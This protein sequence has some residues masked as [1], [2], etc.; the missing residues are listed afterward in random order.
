MKNPK[1]IIFSYININSIRNKFDNLCDLI[2]KNIDI[3][4]VTETKLDPYFSNSQFLIPGFHEPM[5]L[6]V[7]SKRGGMLVYIKSSLPS[8]IMSNFKLPK[9]IQVIPFEL[10]L[11]KEKWFFVSIFKPPLQ[12]NNYFLDTLNDLLDFYSGI[13]DIK[14]VFGN[15]NLEPTNLVMINFMDSQNFTNLIKNSTCFKGVGSCIDLILTNRKYCFKNTS[16]YETG[17]SDHHHLIFSIMK[18]IFASEEPKKFV[19]LDYKTFSH[20][21]FKND[22]MSK[23]V[24]EN[25]DYSK[26]EKEFIDTLNKTCT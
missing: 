22:L 20:E 21:S 24:E 9:N 14:V 6:D 16:S 17:I 25:V 2:L 26:F 5:R 4:S 11:R 12:S 10:N 18:T 3:L 23:T 15:C 8:R 13:Y 7:T 19:Y 1:N